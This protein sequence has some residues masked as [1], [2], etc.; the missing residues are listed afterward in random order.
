MRVENTAL[1]FVLKINRNTR[2]R[3]QFTVQS[4]PKA[5]ICGMKILQIGRNFPCLE[6]PEEAVDQYFKTEIRYSRRH[7]YN[8][9]GWLI[10]D[11]L[12]N[13][14]SSELES[15]MYTDDDS[16]EVSVFFTAKGNATI[17]SHLN[18]VSKDIT[19]AAS[20]EKPDSG[21]ALDFEFVKVPLTDDEKIHSKT[22]KTLGILIAVPVGY[23]SPVRIKFVDKDFSFVDFCSIKVTKVGR[24]LPCIN[25]QQRATFPSKTESSLV[26][27]DDYGNPAAY[28]EI[29]LDLTVCYF[30]NSDSAEENKFQVEVTFRLTAGP[31]AGNTVTIQAVTNVG[32]EETSKESSVT[33][34][35]DVPSFVTISS[36]KYAEVIENTTTPIYAGSF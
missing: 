4:G 22:P 3:L 6:R 11:G 28:K 5:A 25:Q 9:E 8:G 23:S 24:N 7:G 2:G 13:F 14:G 29:Y 20:D 34:S 12:T 32:A 30:H 18:D 33:V 15:N 35:L 36:T 27:L 19:I 21:G 1:R 16:I 10:F 17:T 26:K 31:E